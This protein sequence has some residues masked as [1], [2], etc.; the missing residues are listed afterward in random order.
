VVLACCYPACCYL[1]FEYLSSSPRVPIHRAEPSAREPTPSIDIVSSAPSDKSGRDGPG[2]TGEDLGASERPAN[3]KPFQ[4]RA[5][6]DAPALDS[7]PATADIAMA[8]DFGVND[9]R[10]YRERG[11]SA[12]RSGDLYLALV[13]FNLAISLD[14]NFLGAF[15]DRAVVYH[16]LGDLER[17]L[18]DVAEAKRIGNSDRSNASVTAVKH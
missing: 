16:R 11:V 15:V 10:Y 3:A 2:E 5:I 17:A 14:P 9:A 13:Q 18:A 6:A 7:A 4:E 12:Y 8:R 1:A